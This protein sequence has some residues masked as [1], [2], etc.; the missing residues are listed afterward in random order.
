MERDSHRPPSYK[1]RIWRE[2]HTDHQVIMLDIER[3]SHRPPSYKVRIWRETHT[4]HQV[5]KLEYGERLT[6]TTKT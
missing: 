6:K 1:F 4:D 2:T 5:I 3:D